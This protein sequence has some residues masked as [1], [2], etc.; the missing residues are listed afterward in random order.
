MMPSSRTREVL[1]IE[2]SWRCELHT[3]TIPGEGR[4]L[5]F[6]RQRVA[7]AESVHIGGVDMQTR[8]EILRLRVVRG[9]FLP[10]S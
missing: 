7:T 2:G 4:L 8:A 6:Y 5:V 9:D 1:W 3:S 10:A